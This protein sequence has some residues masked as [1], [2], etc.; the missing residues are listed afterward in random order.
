MQKND[1]K[2]GNEITKPTE[3]A[4]VRTTVSLR[5]TDADF[6]SKIAVDGKMTQNAVMDKALKIA[7]A[8]LTNTAEI[9]RMLKETGS[10]IFE[11]SQERMLDLLPCEKAKEMSAFQK[12]YLAFK[13]RDRKDR[14]RV[15]SIYGLTED[16][17]E[18]N[19][20]DIILEKAAIFKDEQLVGYSAP[21]LANEIRAKLPLIQAEYLNLKIGNEAFTRLKERR[22]D[23]FPDLNLFVEEEAVPVLSDEQVNS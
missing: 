4:R 18:V 7:L 17:N 16:L 5:K 9:E 11:R 3:E 19:D 21:R 22:P 23:L 1:E 15:F 20:I 13:L 14:E 10:F 12:A 8:D 6:L 2:L